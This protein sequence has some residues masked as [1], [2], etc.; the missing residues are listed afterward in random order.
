M[1]VAHG[2]GTKTTNTDG[3]INST[4]Q[5]NSDAGFSIV[6]YSPSNNTGEQ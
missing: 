5:V 4:V 3:D 2:L 6:Q 1:A